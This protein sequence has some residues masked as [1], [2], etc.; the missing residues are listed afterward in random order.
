[1]ASGFRPSRAG[2][3]TPSPASPRN[4]CGTHRTVSGN[5][6]KLLLLMGSASRVRRVPRRVGDG[7]GRFRADDRARSEPAGA[8][9]ARRGR[10][11]E[12]ARSRFLRK[13]GEGQH[14]GNRDFAR[15]GVAFVESRSAAL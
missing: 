9:R 4:L 2:S 13:S 8:R 10:G 11:T 5:E 1:M 15:G 14:G 7:G 6:N 3:E 12:A